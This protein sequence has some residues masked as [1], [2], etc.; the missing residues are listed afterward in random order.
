M[1]ALPAYRLYTGPASEAFDRLT[2]HPTYKA[3][4]NAIVW[5]GVVD[6]L[7][8]SHRRAFVLGGRPQEAGRLGWPCM[9]YQVAS[10][11][12]EVEQRDRAPLAFREQI[13]YLNLAGWLMRP[14]TPTGETYKYGDAL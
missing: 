10:Q 3:I 7:N 12:P 4:F 13:S 14:C 9:A 5:D 1:Q 2:T 11:A 8:H 6:R